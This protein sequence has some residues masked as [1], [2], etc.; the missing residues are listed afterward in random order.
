MAQ[1]QD[2]YRQLS[3]IMME[4]PQ[5]GQRLSNRQVKVL[6]SLLRLSHPKVARW[7]SWSILSS[8]RW[9]RKQSPMIR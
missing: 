7:S 5:A 2:L 6:I 9:P 8:P 1:E 3:E 4:E